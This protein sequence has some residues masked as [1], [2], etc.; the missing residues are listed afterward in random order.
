MFD[1]DELKFVKEPDISEEICAEL[2]IKVFP[3]SLSVVI[4]VEKLELGCVNEPLISDDI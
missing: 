1:K 3:N 4:L 2:L